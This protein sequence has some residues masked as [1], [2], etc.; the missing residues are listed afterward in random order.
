MSWVLELGEGEYKHRHPSVRGH[1]RDSKTTPSGYFD[2]DLVIRVNDTA[3]ILGS[4]MIDSH[5]LSRAI[6]CRFL[7]EMGGSRGRVFGA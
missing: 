3:K 7:F 6:S 2:R 5:P 4:K 1:L